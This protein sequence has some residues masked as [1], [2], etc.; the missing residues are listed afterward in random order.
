MGAAGVFVGSYGPV[1]KE[2]D[3]RSSFQALRG[4]YLGP[5]LPL[6]LPASLWPFG[7]FR[8]SSCCGA[9]PCPERLR[10]L[11]V[12]CVDCGPLG[13]RRWFCPEKDEKGQAISHPLPSRAPSRH[14]RTLFLPKFKHTV[15]LGS[16]PQRGVSSGEPSRLP[17]LRG[18]H[19]GSLLPCGTLL[20]VLKEGL[21]RGKPGPVCNG[22]SHRSR[23]SPFYAACLAAHSSCV[24]GFREAREAR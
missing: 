19:C 5:L 2:K 1:S 24:L 4:P 21:R 22:P 10:P 9:G 3:Y 12:D 15:L 6:P 18:L 23:N 20:P 17:S 13:R 14:L 11:S 16:S 7:F 8:F